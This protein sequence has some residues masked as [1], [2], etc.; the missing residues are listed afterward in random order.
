VPPIAVA[1]AKHPIVDNYDLSNL[2]WLFSGAAPLGAPL[3]EA[4]QARLNVRVRQGYGMTEASPA[5]H[6]TVPGSDRAG[7]IGPL[8]PNS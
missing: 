2:R 5:T 7:K 1:L 6:Y 4:V 3:T 8:M